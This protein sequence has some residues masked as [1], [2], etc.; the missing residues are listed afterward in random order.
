MAASE[1]KKKKGSGKAMIA[2]GAI[3]KWM[4]S[5]DDDRYN[6]GQADWFEKMMML[7]SPKVG[8]TTI[9]LT[10]GESSFY[11]AVHQIATQSKRSGTG[12][13]QKFGD[14][15]A[16]TT[17]GTIGRYLQ[18]KTSPWL[19][20]LTALWDGRDYVGEEYTL[21]KA[22]YG[23]LVPLTFEDIKD[24]L[25]QNGVGTT[26]VTAPLS[27][28][29]AGGT[30][31]DR[32]PY[33]NMVNRFFES[34]KEFD[35]IESDDLLDEQYRKTLLDSIRDTNPLMRDDVREDIAADIARIRKDEAR[36]AKDAKEGNE[37]DVDLL[38]VIDE[39]KAKLIEKIRRF[40][41]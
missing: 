21:G 31:Y 11:R 41:R 35:R 26:L 29:G 34:K 37:P 40:R 16:P 13:S 9:D 24:Q 6:F 2:I 22:I 18:G 8:N 32:K 28:L 10:G 23:G 14:Y 36:I 15:G 20:E 33:E 30:T 3:L 4:F 12:R 25:V 19:S 38:S 5:D 7:A 27:I 1:K 39:N 17:M